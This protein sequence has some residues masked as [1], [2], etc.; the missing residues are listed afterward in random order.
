[1]IIKYNKQDL[2]FDRIGIVSSRVDKNILKYSV[3]IFDIKGYPFQNRTYVL[4]VWYTYIQ[5]LLNFCRPA[6]SS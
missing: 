6:S 2:R 3:W 1:M 5:Y 4:Y